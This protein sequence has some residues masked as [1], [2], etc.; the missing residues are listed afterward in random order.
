ME[1]VNEVTLETKELVKSFHSRDI[2]QGVSLKVKQGEVIGLLGPNGAGKTT[3]F[4]MIIGLMR[5]DKGHIFLN[6]QDIAH[7]PIYK[8]AR[9]G[10]GYLPQE[11]SVFRKMS[12][13]ENILVIMEGLDLSIAQKE[14]RS[15]E[16][17]EE[18]N[19]KPIRYQKAETLSGGE[20]RRL[21]IARALVPGPLFMLLDEPFAGID[22]KAVIGIQDI[23]GKLK[24]KGI[25]VIITDHNVRE[26]LLIT[27][28]SY[29]IFK[30]E[31]LIEGTS[32]ELVKDGRA[33]ELYLG[34]GFRL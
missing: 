3:I 19:L 1:L 17:I 22:P 2:V 24:K 33:R 30:G 28:R 6:S 8:R 12:V 11:P 5:P 13:E 7:E 14:A 4:K 21:E 15:E 9:M 31:V 20:R 32:Y 23:L 27:D 34:E 18:F 25:G 26:T 10:L 16:L 29:I